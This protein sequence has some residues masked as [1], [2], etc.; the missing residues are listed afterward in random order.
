MLL[1]AVVIAGTGAQYLHIIESRADRI[2]FSNRLNEEI[3]RAKYNRAMYG[4]TYRPEYIQNN[5]AN[6]E[7][8]VKLIDRG[9]RWTGTPKAAGSA[10]SGDADR[11]ISTAA[12]VFEQAVTAKDAVRQSWNMSEVQAS[13]SRGTPADQQRS[14]AGLY[15][16]EPEADL[17]ATARA[18][19][20]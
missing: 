11:G 16:T 14:A 3:N 20:Y 12:K 9:R 5:R 1:L 19:C 18:A 17:C 4:Q 7:N 15:P 2:D 6:I 10:A 13:L 8:A